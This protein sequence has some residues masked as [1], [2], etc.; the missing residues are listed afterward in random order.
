MKRGQPGRSPL[1]E[2]D[3]QMLELKRLKG[4]EPN[5]HEASTHV[6]ESG[7]GAAASTTENDYVAPFAET[8][9]P[10]LKLRS[11]SSPL[12]DTVAELESQQN[13][14]RKELLELDRKTTQLCA[15]REH[16]ENENTRLQNELGEEVEKVKSLTK[17]IVVIIAEKDN[18]LKEKKKLEGDLTQDR[19]NLAQQK[20]R[21]AQLTQ[22]CDSLR[23]TIGERDEEV[24]AMFHC[25][26][27]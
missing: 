24:G 11:T 14:K 4:V 2:A 9:G 23:T 10:S 6:L 27:H 1:P 12:Q 20:D 5:K 21:V 22:E 18:L 25:S 16:L 13:E 7:S 15:E 17:Q 26:L 3:T 19:Q 8:S